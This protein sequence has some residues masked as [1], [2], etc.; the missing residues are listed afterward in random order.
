MKIE[1]VSAGHPAYEP[2]VWADNRKISA[3]SKSISDPWGWSANELALLLGEKGLAE[4]ENGK[5]EFNVTT[6]HFKLVTGQRVCKN[7]H[8]IKLLTEYEIL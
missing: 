7:T 1:I 8:E 5:Y 4:Y 6:S 2:N 3:P